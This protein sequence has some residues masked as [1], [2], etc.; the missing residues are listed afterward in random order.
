MPAVPDS[1]HFQKEAK[2]CELAARMATFLEAHIPPTYYDFALP[3]LLYFSNEE[4]LSALRE[5]TIW[6]VL[7]RDFLANRGMIC[8]AWDQLEDVLPILKSQSTLQT[9]S[10][11]FS[12]SARLIMMTIGISAMAGG[13]CGWFLPHFQLPILSTKDIHSK[14]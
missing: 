4:A 2:R 9:I 7:E 6:Q 10:Q 1:T 8:E 3:D 14:P 13:L 11:A 12:R 5:N